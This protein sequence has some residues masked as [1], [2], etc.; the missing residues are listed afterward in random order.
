MMT[1]GSVIEVPCQLECGPDDMLFI[2][3]CLDTSES[4]P[5]QETLIVCVGAQASNMRSSTRAKGVDQAKK[6]AMAEL[7]AAKNAKARKSKEEEKA[8]RCVCFCY[9]RML[10]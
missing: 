7:V 9:P 3:S 10:K 6:S 5:V 1:I 4:G 8:K 2:T